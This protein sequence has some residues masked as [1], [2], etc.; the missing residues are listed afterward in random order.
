MFLS[1]HA[2][3]GYE[4][5]HIKPTNYDKGHHMYTSNGS[6]ALDFNG[7]TPENELLKAHV[8]ACKQKYPGWE[9]ERIFVKEGLPGYA[10][11]NNHRPPEYFPY[12]PWERAYNYINSFRCSHQKA[13]PSLFK[14]TFCQHH[15]QGQ[16]GNFGSKGIVCVKMTALIFVIMIQ[17]P[18]SGFLGSFLGARAALF[19][20][21]PA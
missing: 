5:I 7:W 9:Y 2:D 21:R 3:E 16:P 8:A 11:K 13:S 12:L 18:S 14:S 20:T 15:R 4:L 6:W 10:L 17:V 1:L 19:L